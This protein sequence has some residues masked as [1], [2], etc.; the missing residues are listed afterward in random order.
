[1]NLSNKS[2]AH[3]QLAIFD[4][5]LRKQYGPFLCGTDEAGRGAFA[6]PIVAA[7]CILPEDAVLE[8]LNDSKQMTEKAREDL[9]EQIKKIALAYDIV[10]ID[11]CLIDKYGIDACNVKAMSNSCAHTTAKN[12]DQVSLYIVDQSPGF[13]LNPHIMMSKAD[14][15]SLCVAAASVLAKTYRDNLMCK[16]ALDHP[17]YYWEENKGYIN[18]A[19]KEGIVKHGITY[20]HRKT[21]KVSGITKPAQMSYNDLF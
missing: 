10:A 7:A 16:L 4:H 17:G 2:K 8:G 5:N 11:A 3:E 9:V 19:H 12:N 14:A 21:Y 13:E 1:M 15:T 20:L 6:G 18:E